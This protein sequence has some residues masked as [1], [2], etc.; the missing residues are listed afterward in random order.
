[1]ADINRLIEFQN[2]NF[3]SETKDTDI[4]VRMSTR[5]KEALKMMAKARKMKVSELIMTLLQ[6]EKETNMILNKVLEEDFKEG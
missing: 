5:Q 1:M 4:R 2:T 6:Y 3:S